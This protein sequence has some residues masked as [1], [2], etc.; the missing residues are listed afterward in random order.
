LLAHLL[1]GQSETSLDLAIE[2][3]DPCGGPGRR[4]SSRE[5]VIAR[6]LQAIRPELETSS[7]LLSR[8]L[9]VPEIHVDPT[10]SNPPLTRAQV[11]RAVL[12]MDAFTRCTV[13]LR[14]LEGLALDETAA[15][16]GASADLIR[17]AQ[18]VGLAALTASLQ[19]ATRLRP[20][21]HIAFRKD[22]VNGH[23]G[24]MS[25]QPV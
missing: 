15:L 11:E 20:S 16:L 10:A 5:L 12:S 8:I 17:Q 1:T 21:A 4:Q 24:W 22:P 14:I 3:S 6:A 18:V 2:F 13:V 7:R 19:R 23:Q 9:D 25:V